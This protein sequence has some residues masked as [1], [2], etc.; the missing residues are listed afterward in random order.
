VD[1]QQ[2][3][4]K[5]RGVVYHSQDHFISHFITETGSVWYHDGLSTGQQME[6]E[7]DANITDFETC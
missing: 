5:L 3:T 6:H 1:G 4:Y 7:G 2:T